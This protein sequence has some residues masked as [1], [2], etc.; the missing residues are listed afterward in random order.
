MTETDAVSNFQQAKEMM[1]SI[2]ALGCQFA[3]DDFGVGFSTFN[4]MREL[5]MDTIKLDGIFIKDLDKNADD[6]L[7]LKHCLMSQK[8][9]VRKPSLN[10]S[11]TKLFYKYSGTLALTMLEAITLVNLNH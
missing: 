8:N 7:L 9:W 5:P 6:Q 11:K 4:Y 1:T 10:L 3:L 2:K